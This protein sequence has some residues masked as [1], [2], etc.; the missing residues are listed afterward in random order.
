M[1]LFCLKYSFGEGIWKGTVSENRPLAHHNL[2]SNLEIKLC[3]S[4]NV[5]VRVRFTALCNHLGQKKHKFCWCERKYLIV[6]KVSKNG[7]MCRQ[8]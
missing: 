3:G 5:W 7:C 8:I 2:L 1:R 6:I 4:S